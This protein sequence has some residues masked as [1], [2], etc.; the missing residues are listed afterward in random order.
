MIVK[1]KGD[2]TLKQI[3][4]VYIASRKPIVSLHMQ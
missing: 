2:I 1:I 3:N 4:F